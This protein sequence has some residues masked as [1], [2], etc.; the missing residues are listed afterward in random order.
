MG[1]FCPHEKEP[2]RVNAMKSSK[3]S[4]ISILIVFAVAALSGQKMLELWLRNR[5][6]AAETVSLRDAMLH[7]ILHRPATVAYEGVSFGFGERKLSRACPAPLPPAGT[8]PLWGR[9]PADQHCKSLSVPPGH[10]DLR[11]AHH[12]PGPGE[13]GPHRPVH[14][15]VQGCD[16]DRH[17]T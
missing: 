15:C 5:M 14:L 8:M 4:R 17:H 10:P 7:S 12:R 1:H 6:F 3:T 13:C 2:Q 11:R 16:A 9:A